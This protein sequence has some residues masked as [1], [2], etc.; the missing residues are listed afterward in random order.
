M[1]NRRHG[2]DRRRIAGGDSG[3]LSKGIGMC[4]FIEGKNVTL[5]VTGGI[6]AYKSIELLR[7]LTKA[8]ARVRVIMTENACWF[9]GPGTF[10]APFRTAG[11]HQCIRRRRC[12]DPAYRLGAIHRPGGHCPGHGQLHR[13]TGRWSC[14]RCAIHLHAGRDSPGGRL[15]GHEYEHVPAPVRP[16]QSG[17]PA[18]LW[19]HPGR[20]GCRTT[21][22]WHGRARA[23]ARA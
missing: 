18:W 10:Q 4:H 22:V 12:R 6:A 20:S 19:P 5:G 17:N 8:G 21:G 15:P 11:L 1:P 7:L 16:A 3:T 23:F 2:Q 9:V 13:Q 14:R